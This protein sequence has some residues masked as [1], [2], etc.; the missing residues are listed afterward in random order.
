MTLIFIM[1]KKVVRNQ[2]TKDRILKIVA[3]SVVV[4]HFSS[5]YEDFFSNNGEA[6]VE[7]NMLLPI[8]PCNIIMWLLLIVS[9]MKNKESIIYKT[10]SE[11][12]FIGGTICGL[13]G[14]LFNINFLNN[15]NF[16]DYDIFKGLISHTVMIFGTIYLFVFKY[17][18]LEVARTTKS[19]FWGLIIFAVDGIV[20]NALFYYF[21]LDSVNAM[22]MLEPPFAGLPQFN[23][24]SLGVMGVVGCFIGLNIYEYVVFPKGRRWLNKI[25]IERKK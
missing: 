22:Y 16:F 7:D 10:L 13:A 24:L 3:I 19:I 14:V 6:L 20:I 8:Y 1:C 4:I 17:V 11:F 25:L 9:F 18:K 5:L 2:N 12:T 21:G 15:P 23:F